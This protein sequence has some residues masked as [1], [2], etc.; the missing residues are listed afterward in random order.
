MVKKFDFIFTV[1]PFI[2]IIKYIEPL[3]PI[4]FM[5]DERNGLLSKKKKKFS[6]SRLPILSFFDSLR[7]F[8]THAWYTKRSGGSITKSAYDP[9]SR[10]RLVC[11][12]SRGD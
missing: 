11:L 7:L 8:S 2:Q 1:L 6:T 9:L 5:S 12:P 10:V 4:R 3:S